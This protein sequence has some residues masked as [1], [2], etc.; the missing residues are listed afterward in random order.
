MSMVEPFYIELGR[1]IEDLRT[2]KKMSKAALG[3]R[4]QPELSRA[5]IANIESG[6]QRVLVHTLVEIANALEVEVS[7]LIPS[8]KQTKK[9]LRDKLVPIEEIV[10]ALRDEGIPRNTIIEIRQTIEGN[11]I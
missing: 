5:S 8:R 6:K 11:K 2:K 3:R 4:L 10:N 7:E 9:T 1:L